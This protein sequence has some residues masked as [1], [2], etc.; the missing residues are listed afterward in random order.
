MLYCRV[1]P[2]TLTMDSSCSL[3]GP[4]CGSKKER[5]PCVISNSLLLK[6]T[7]PS[8]TLTTPRGTGFDAVPLMSMSVERIT[9]ATLLRT[10]RSGPLLMFRSSLMCL[11]KG[12]GA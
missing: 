4:P 11:R 2:W 10:M 9:C 7:L 8:S 12:L 3:G 1:V 6:K 5:V